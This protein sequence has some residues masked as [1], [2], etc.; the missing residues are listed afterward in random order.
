MFIPPFIFLTFLSYYVFVLMFSQGISSS[1]KLLADASNEEPIQSPLT[2]V[3]ALSS[4]KDEDQ[5]Q[6]ALS[7]PSKVLAVLKGI[8]QVQDTPVSH[9]FSKYMMPKT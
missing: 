5:K 4:G 1:R 6:N 9:M 8:K 2:P 7:K 3:L